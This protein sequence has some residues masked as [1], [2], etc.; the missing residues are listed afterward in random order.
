[1]ATCGEVDF[2]IEGEPKHKWDKMALVAA[3]SWSKFFKKEY[4]KIVELLFYGQ[5]HCMI[6]GPECI[7][8]STTTNLFNSSSSS[9]I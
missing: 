8:K 5:Y 3:D 2:E 9:S 6:T 7:Y 4:S 1:M